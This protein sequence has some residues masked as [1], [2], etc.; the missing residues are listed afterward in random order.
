MDSQGVQQGAPRRTPDTADWFAEYGIRHI[1]IIPD[2]NRRWAREHS[3][4]IE[5]GHTNGLLQV[6][7][8]LVNKLCDAGVHTITVWGFSTE[9]WT[10]EL[11]EVTHLMD[12]I[13]DFLRHHIMS[14]AQRHDARICHL[15][16]KDRLYPAVRD[17]LI[18]AEAATALNRSHVYNVALDYGGEDEL[19]RASGRMVAAMQDRTLKS[20]LS[21]VDFL[22]TAGQPHPQ[23]DLLVRSSGEQRMSGFLPLQTAYS[24]LFFLEEKFPEF[25]FELLQ[26]VAK[27]F[28]W[29]KRRFG[30]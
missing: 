12:I 29:R 2:G 8:E 23:P 6:L 16:R 13:A 15:G 14:I 27:Q 17:A 5:I 22:D 1:A 4:P 30:S 3:F 26:E 20:D 9:N 28:K 21:L 24:E 25:T 7:P 11:S 19:V 10:R 18:T